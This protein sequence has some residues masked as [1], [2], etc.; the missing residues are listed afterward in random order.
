MTLCVVWRKNNNVCFAS[1]SRITF[2]INS[3]ADVGIKVM[4]VPYRVYSP[5]DENNNKHLSFSGELGMCFSGSVSNSM[6]I[7][8]TV[9]EVLKNLQYVPNYTNVS[10]DNIASFIFKV[11]KN[12]SKEVCST[13]LH[14]NG[15]ADIIIAGHCPT[16]NKIKVFKFATDSKNVHS[17]SEILKNEGDYEFSGSGAKNAIGIVSGKK[18]SPLDLINALKKTIDDEITAPDVGGNIQYGTFL[19]D[20]FVIYGIVEYIEDDGVKYWRGF[21]DLN[22]EEYSGSYDDFVLSYRYI[23]PFQTFNKS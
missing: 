2:G 7:K 15:I 10:I 17:C 3:Y 18:P 1:D 19:G 6:F 11:Y 21:L 4:A 16:A 5:C 23:D 13:L 20:S 22:S 12:I 8:E 14:K 9:I